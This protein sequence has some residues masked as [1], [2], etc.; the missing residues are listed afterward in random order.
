[1][2]DTNYCTSVSQDALVANRIYF[3]SCQGINIQLSMHPA[4]RACSFAGLKSHQFLPLFHSASINEISSLIRPSFIFLFLSFI[5]I[6]SPRVCSHPLSLLRCSMDIIRWM[7]SAA[8]VLVVCLSWHIPL[9]RLCPYS[10]IT[11]FFPFFSAPLT[12]FSAPLD[13][14]RVT[15][16]YPSLPTI[17][18]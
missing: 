10:Y 8:W 17:N 12:S 2:S 3:H 14:V 11:F 7:V 13:V 5:F 4:L 6:S 9:L 18:L 1:M 16:I 15:F